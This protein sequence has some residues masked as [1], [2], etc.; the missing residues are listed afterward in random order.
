M[1]EKANE[2]TNW[3][4]VKE[5]CAGRYRLLFLWNV[6]R[7]FRLSG[8]KVILYPIVFFIFLF[9]KNG[10]LAS[11]KYRETLYAYQRK[12]KITPLKFSAYQHIFSYAFSLAEKMSAIC[13]LKSS[14][15]FDIEKDKNWQTFQEDLKEG[16]F[17]IS[18]HLGNIEALSALPQ[19]LPGKC[20]KVNALMQISQNSIFHQFIQEKACN[21]CFCLYSAE[22]FGFSEIMALYEKIVN[23]EMVLMAGDRVSTQNSKDTL[24]VKIL[25][26][27]CFLPKGVFQFA[28]KIKHPTYTVLLLRTTMGSHKLFLKKLDILKSEQVFANEYAAFLEKYLLKYP[29]QWYNFFDFFK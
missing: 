14:L 26:K 4:A 18:S 2:M 9:S 29:D 15:R 10:R 6:Y 12:H 19:Q 8:L 3:Y 7:I 24:P 5:Q 20:P 16:V 13:D 21:S 1:Y 17:L 28:K 23:G 27:K 25:D 22:Q 11:K